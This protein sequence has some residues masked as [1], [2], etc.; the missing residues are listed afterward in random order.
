VCDSATSQDG[1]DGVV[2]GVL[3]EYEG[4]ETVYAGVHGG[5]VVGG[6]E[7]IED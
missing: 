1:R 3:G 2:E 6:R 4:G 5:E 7:G